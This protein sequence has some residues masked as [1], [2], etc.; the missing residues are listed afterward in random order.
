M[1]CNVYACGH[2]ISQ[3][4]QINHC[5]R[6]NCRFSPNHPEDCVPPGCKCASYRMFPDQYTVN[7]EGPCPDCQAGE[8][9]QSG[10]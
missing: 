3:P 1:V 2:R 7:V 8:M 6:T 9:Y 4:E 10:A 5:Y